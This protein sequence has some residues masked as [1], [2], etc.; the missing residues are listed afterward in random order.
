LTRPVHNATC[1]VKS[2]LTATGALLFNEHYSIRSF[3][4]AI[5]QLPARA[6]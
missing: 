1:I 2:L 6:T 3:V 5:N 4:W